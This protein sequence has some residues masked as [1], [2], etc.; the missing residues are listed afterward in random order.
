[1]TAY[2]RRPYTCKV[3]AVIFDWAGTTVDYGCC[4]PAGVFVRAF[5]AHGLDV[6]VEQAR[7]PMGVHKREHVRML[8][9]LDPVRRQFAAAHGRAPTAA[10]VDTIYAD[11]TRLQIA[12]LADY[13]DP[14]PG[15]LE[16]VAWLRRRDIKVG[17]CTG[18]VTEMMD[19]LVPAAAA[20][21]FQ[22][23]A[24]VCASD[25]PSA[26]PAPLM[27]LLNLVRLDTGP[28]QA[29]VKVGDTV[30][31]I[32]EGLNAGM[33]TVGVT[34]TGNEV[35]LT[36]AA[37]AALDEAARQQRRLRAADKLGRAGAHYLIDG[38]ADLPAVIEAI[39]TRLAVGEAP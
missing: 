29:C 24:W 2:R 12:C 14:I 17:S 31:D 32:E 18:Y 25:V 6:S 5:G 28:V 10:D 11:A 19:V 13:A 34:V 22:P 7:G 30:A 1:M 16:T 36:A 9:D 38:V 21:G 37:L 35:G 39:D 33:W 8:L 27:A 23:D 20:K 4:A 26:R 3:R 15:T